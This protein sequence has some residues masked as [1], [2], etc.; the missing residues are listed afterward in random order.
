MTKGKPW[1][2]EE[3]TELKRLVEARTPVGVMAE[4]LGRKPDALLIK[5][6]RLGLADYR[7]T[8][9]TSIPLPKELP[10]VEETLKKL[11]GA[12]EVASA[13]G[14]NKIEIQR[15]QVVATIA[16]TYK[17]ILV[18]YINYREIEAK[19]NA[20]EEKYAQ[21]LQENAENPTT[22]S[23]PAQVAQTPTQ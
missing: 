21:L 18:D 3:E 11:A 17:E 15:L 13:P 20:M 1:S 22:E 14:L 23:N 8:I 10:S 5:C 16:K 9:N 2:V 12:L 4:K 19:L 6:K 7:N